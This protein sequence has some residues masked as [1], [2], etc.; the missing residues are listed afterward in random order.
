MF[1]SRNDNKN[2]FHSNFIT[3]ELRQKMKKKM[4]KVQYCK[5]ISKVN[6]RHLNIHV[7]RSKAH[8]AFIIQLKTSKIEF[9]KFLHK[10]YVFDV[11]IAHCSCDEKY[12]IVKH[13]LFFCPN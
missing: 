10:K 11:L 2:K 12:I 6:H 8:N 1:L 4:K 3:K 13:M 7:K 9:N 5:L